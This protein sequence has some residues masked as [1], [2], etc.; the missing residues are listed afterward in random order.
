MSVLF[1]EQT[2]RLALALAGVLQVFG[3]LAIRKIIDIDI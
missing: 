3:Y 1:E 2:G